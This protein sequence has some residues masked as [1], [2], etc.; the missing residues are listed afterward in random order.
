MVFRFRRHGPKTWAS[1]S[2]IVL[3]FSACGFKLYGDFHQRF[4]V[5]T[6]FSA[7]SWAFFRLGLKMGLNI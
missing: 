4:V 5:S 1:G 3:G 7:Q 2:K 6:G